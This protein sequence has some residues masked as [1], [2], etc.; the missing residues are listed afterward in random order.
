[1]ELR[2]LLNGIEINE[3]IGFDGF[4]PVIERTDHHG[5]SVSVSLS[6]IGFYG[7][8]IEIIEDSY[9][10][11]IDT[12]LPFI[13]EINRDG[14]WNTIYSGVIDLAS[15]ERVNENGACRINCNVGEIGIKT[16]FNNRY[17]TKVE[18]N[19]LTS[20]D[21]DS[22]PEYYM[23]KRNVAFPSKEILLTN[24][25]KL[26]KDV[27]SE[28]IIEHN[29]IYSYITRWIFI[30]LGDIVANEIESFNQQTEMAPISILDNDVTTPGGLYAMII[31]D[32]VC[33]F[34]FLQN[35]FI[36]SPYNFNIKIQIKFIALFDFSDCRYDSSEILILLCTSDGRIKDVINRYMLN[37]DSN[38]QVNADVS[39]EGSVSMEYGE[40]IAIL[41]TFGLVQTFTYHFG[42][43]I[44]YTAINGSGISI[45]AISQAPGS[46]HNVSLVHESLSRLSEIAI[47]KLHNN[48]YGLTVKSDFYS[49]GNS[50]VNKNSILNYFGG[51]S[52]KAIL[53]GYELRNT[54]LTSGDRPPVKLSFKDLFESLNAIDNIGWGFSEEKDEYE[55]DILYLRIERWQWFYKDYEIMRI[56]NPNNVKRTIQAD[57]VYTGLKIGYEKYLDEQEINAIDTFHTNR[58]YYTGLKSID[59][60]LEKICKFIADPYAIEV[61][62]RQQFNKDTSNWKYDEDTFI[63]TLNFPF[64]I[65]GQYSP[66]LI[67]VGITDTEDDNNT[68]TVISPGTMY[69]MRI[70][71]QRNAI[72]WAERFFEVTSNRNSLDYTAGTGNVTAKGKPIIAN[73]PAGA[74]YY[75]EDSASGESI[76]ERENISRKA[77]ILKPEILS[78]DYPISFEQ[79]AAILANPYGK[80]I[81]DGEE[82]YIKKV[83]PT[84]VGNIASFELIPK[85]A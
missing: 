1:M 26:G 56:N 12:E 7:K 44:T 49:R 5:M 74:I 82:C 32:E 19:R 52:L 34:I 70:S 40:K 51:G 21:G 43:E 6:K 18:L 72:R 22:L 8:A 15:Y 4:K 23:L 46:S 66:F 37:I 76:S 78:F 73:F 50:E 77:P 69:N 17:D 28:K 35:Q 84:L 25:A 16:T 75:L 55:N 61:T 58:E 54:D 63:V 57:K 45:R 48:D 27:I 68:A 14:N 62:R 80:I 2:F 30:P 42:Y 53:N 81:V 60:K 29:D 59:N 64:Y 24:S 39:F 65:A 33:S 38:Q 3:P 20:L 83:T 47:G 13:V 36:K 10:T 71:P 11:D 67:D 85:N 31:P 79:Y 9:I 41:Y